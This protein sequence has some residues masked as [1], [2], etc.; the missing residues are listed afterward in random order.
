[1]KPLI[2]VC[3]G[4]ACGSENVTIST[5][6]KEGR[7]VIFTRLQQINELVLHFRG[8]QNFIIC[9][10]EILSRWSGLR[11]RLLMFPTNGHQAGHFLLALGLKKQRH[12]ILKSRQ[13]I[14][15]KMVKEF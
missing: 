13:V 8:I 4:A 9:C 3:D 14:L 15:K 7:S 10:Y 6:G 5:E 11:T 12:E 1:M 2:D